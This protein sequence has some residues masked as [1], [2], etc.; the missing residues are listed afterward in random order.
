LCDPYEVVEAATGNRYE[1]GRW[2]ENPDL[3]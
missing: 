1:N 3:R 2:A